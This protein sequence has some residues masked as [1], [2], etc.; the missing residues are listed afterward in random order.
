MNDQRESRKSSSTL[1]L[2]SALDGGG[3]LPPRPNWFIPRN[4]V[5]PIV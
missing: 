1:S 2:N 5:V 3:C 4:G